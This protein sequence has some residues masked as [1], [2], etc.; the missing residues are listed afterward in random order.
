M[1]SEGG[2][3]IQL[4]SACWLASEIAWKTGMLAAVELY[5]ISFS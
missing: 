1:E 4:I 2:V 3:Y 5:M